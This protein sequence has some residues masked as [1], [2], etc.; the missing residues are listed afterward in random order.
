M[1]TQPGCKSRYS[2]ATD[3]NL[4]EEEA[5]RPATTVRVTDPET[6]F[7]LAGGFYPV[8]Q[9]AWRWT[10]QRFS[11]LLR[12]PR[13]AA[14]KGATLRLNLFVPDPVIAKLG[15][16]S[17]EASIAGKRL[18][19]ETYGKVGNYIYSRD[20]SSNLLPG[21]LVRVD[22][23]LRKAIIAEPP[24]RRELGVIVVSA[25]LEGK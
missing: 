22:F 23:A 13:D 14:R 16:T 2:A 3:A 21:E 12:P 20:V 10:A 11:F 18:G 17:L 9:N 19:E 7:Q 5:S 24:D 6:S 1:F 8:E 4:T 15:S 25:G